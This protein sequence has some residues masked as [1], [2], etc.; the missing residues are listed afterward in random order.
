M[1]A[2]SRTPSALV[3]PASACS[4]RRI[5]RARAWPG[6]VDQNGDPAD[7]CEYAC[8]P[9]GPEVCDGVDNDCN[10]LIDNDDPGLV[11]PVELLPA[12]RRMRQGTGGRRAPGL[13]RPAPTFPV[14]TIPPGAPPAT[15]P[16]WICNYPA[17]VEL[18]A[19]NQ[20]VAQ[21][22]WCDGLDNDCN[23]VAD[24]PYRARLGGS[25]ADPGSTAVGACL[26][27]GTWRCQ[28]NAL[29]CDLGGAV[30]SLPADEICDGV[31]ND[32]DGLVDESWDNPAGLAQ[33]QGHD[34]LGVRDDVVH[35]SATG[36]PGNYYIYRFEASRADASAA[37]Q[38]TATARA[39]SRN[40]DGRAGRCCRG[41]T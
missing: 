33:C 9:N 27:M 28:A 17:T 30:A 11:Y 13:R 20:I 32:C 35:V 4:T 18:A 40:G 16:S 8:T 3:W 23:G 36:A 26:P 22:S 41:A 24:D 14:C 39:C 31:D 6:W 34:C 21:E 29:V 5:A 12:D 1:L 15:A 10:G 2:A 19:P 25:C 37:A 7:G 38:G